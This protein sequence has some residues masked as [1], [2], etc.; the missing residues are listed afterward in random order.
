MAKKKSSGDLISELIIKEIE[1]QIN[2]IRISDLE[3]KC[4]QIIT[5]KI[6]ELLE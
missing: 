2:S 1:I 5:K 6:N 4:Y 3:T